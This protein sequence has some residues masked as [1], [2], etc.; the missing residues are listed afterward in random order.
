MN[1]RSWPVTVLLSVSLIAMLSGCFSERPIPF[2]QDQLV[3]I[4]P[5]AAP[6][7]ARQ[8]LRHAQRRL[9]PLLGT[10]AKRTLLTEDLLD[11]DGRPIDVLKRY[12]RRFD[13]QQS[14]FYN[15]DGL[16]HTAQLTGGD[17][18][19]EAPP[20]WPGYEQVWIPVAPG[21]ELA[22]FL[23]YARAGEAPAAPGRPPSTPPSVMAAQAGIRPQSIPPGAILNADCIVVLPGLLGHNGV[24]RSFD[25]SEAL[26]ASGRHALAVELRGHG[27][28]ERRFPG[29]AYNFGTLETGDLM[30]VA[31]WLQAKPHIRRTGLVGFCWGANEALLAAWYDGRDEAHPSI[32]SRLAP[33]LRPVTPTRHYE[34]GVIAFSPVLSFEEI[35]GRVDRV[36]SAIVNPVLAALQDTIRGRMTSKGY[37]APD[38]SLRRLID[39]EFS[40]SEL[41]YPEAVADA[42][43]FLRFLP[44]RGRPD[45]DKLMSARV[46]VLIVQAANDPLACAQDV[47]DLIA[48]TPA[49]NVAAIVLP[50]GGHVGFAAY[51]ARFTYSLMLNFFDPARGAAAVRDRAKEAR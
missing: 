24:R 36:R 33:H 48:R 41:D 40:H 46:P 4:D 2:R 32:H 35:I 12:A 30:A 42:L 25:V 27:Q 3:E 10:D 20:P 45:G 17:Y 6:L 47:A 5:F 22:G 16:S 7:D 9:A 11:K 38:G 18:A 28:T 29:I 21:L 49:P 51:N 8:W 23:G 43:D 31:E 1:L 50:G 19:A 13:R 37:D 15:C 44:F 26:R 39:A 34:A 14:L